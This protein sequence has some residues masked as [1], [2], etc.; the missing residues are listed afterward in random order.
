MKKTSI[1]NNLKTARNEMNPDIRKKASETIFKRL[2]SLPVYKNSDSVFIFVSMGSEVETI[3]WIPEILKEKK[4]YVPL[5][6]KGGAMIMT[7]IMTEIKSLDELEPNP[8]GILE[9]PGDKIKDRRR[10]SVD[11]IITPGLAFD[12]EGYRMGYGG[13]YYDRFFATHDGHRLGV[14][15]HD[16]LVEELPRDE[17][18]LP[19]DAFLSEKDYLSFS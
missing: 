16:Q 4:V 17:Y 14:G 18:D 19:V 15:F 6:P 13:G 1:R 9:L 12:G 2:K 11:L 5:A 3:Q 8:L 7:M 10:E